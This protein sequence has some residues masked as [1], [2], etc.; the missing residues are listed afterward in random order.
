MHIQ[1][2]QKDLETAASIVSSLIDR[3]AGPMPV[4]SNLLIDVTEQGVQFRGTDME[5]MVTVNLNATIHETGRTT[6][7]AD[8]FRELVRLLPPMAEVE[9]EESNNKVH[10][11]CETNNYNLM[12]LPAEDFPVWPAS[13]GTTKFQISQRMLKNL[14]DATTYALP[15]KDH[16]RVLLGVFFELENHDLQ[17]TA[18][19]G[20]KLARMSTTIPEVEGNGTASIVVPRKVLEN[21]SR[22]LG[23]EGPVEVEITDPETSNARQIVFRFENVLYRCNGIDGKYPDCNAVI[24]KD[25][26]IQIKINREVVL[27][28]AKRAGVVAN[29]EKSKSIVLLIENNSCEFRSM[30]HDIGTFSGKIPLDYDGA[31]LELAFNFEY[32]VE[33]LSRFN[34]SEL[35]ILIK[36]PKSPVV[37]KN[38]EEERRLSLLMPIKLADVRPTESPEEV[39]A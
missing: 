34:S 32:L 4:L 22:Y 9:L 36:S 3:S 24:P 37:I 7:P 13:A 27:Q 6:V 29:D 1:L 38:M 33:T 31:P 26:P 25:F 21:V 2:P 16:R 10:V 12:T 39:E 15:S 35:T 5:A 23:T 17:L 19:D 20:K 18:T 8:K 28:G 14:I 11:Q 30:A